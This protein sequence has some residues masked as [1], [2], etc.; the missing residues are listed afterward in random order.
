METAEHAGPLRTLIVDDEPIAR[1]LLREELEE[2]DGVEVVGEAENGEAAVER[3]E[4]L[5]PDLVLLDIQMPV[6]NG[7][8]VIRNVRGPLP[9]VIFVTAYSEHALRAFEVGAVDYLLKPVSEERLRVAV[10]RARAAGRNSLQ[11]AE[12]VARTLNAEN[13]GGEAKRLKV[14]AKYGRRY[15]LLD[16][17]E[18]FAFQAEGEIVRIFTEDR[19]FTATQT[20]QGIEDG[21]AGSRFQRLRRGVLANT[22]KIRTLSALSSQRWLVTL[23]NGLEFAVSKRQAPVVRDLL[24]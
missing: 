15:H 23:T 8:E 19:K 22:D 2:I 1:R 24:R 18:V 21:L 6:Q 20:L 16:L 11:E 5:T 10:E 9:S 7:F 14:V 13:A 17:D 12:R 3:V 4:A